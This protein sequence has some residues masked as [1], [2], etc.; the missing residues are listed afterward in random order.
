MSDQ[1][2]IYKTEIDASI[3]MSIQTPQGDWVKSNVRLCTHIGPGFPDDAMLSAV[4]HNQ[5]LKAY[6]GCADQIQLLVSKL[7][8]EVSSG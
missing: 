4:L 7:N 8:T 6:E 2:R 5:V 3:G 1:Q